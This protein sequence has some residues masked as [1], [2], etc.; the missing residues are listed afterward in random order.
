MGTFLPFASCLTETLISTYTGHVKARSPAQGPVLDFQSSP[1]ATR[2]GGAVGGLSTAEIAKSFLAPE[3]TVGQRISRA[4]PGI[5]TSRVP[6]RS[7]N[8][9]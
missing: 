6:F 5:K 9:N 3:S 2:S 8:P 4:K 1:A 7:C